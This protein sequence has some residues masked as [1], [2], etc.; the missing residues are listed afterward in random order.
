MLQNHQWAYQQIQKL[1]IC[2]EEIIRHPCRDVF[3]MLRVTA[4]FNIQGLN[5]HLGWGC[6]IVHTVYYYEV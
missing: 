2:P 4:L 1:K 6:F 5:I 3:T